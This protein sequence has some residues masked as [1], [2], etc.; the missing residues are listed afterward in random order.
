MTAT[1]SALIMGASSGIGAATARALSAAGHAV[2]LMARRADQLEALAQE[3][4]GTW[5]AVDATDAK[6]VVAA[7]DDAA[8]SGPP[9]RIAVYAAGVLDVAAVDGHP[10]ES[11]RRTIDVNL[12]G[13]FYF[14]RA[15]VPHLDAGDGSS[16]SRP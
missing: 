7:V 3:T 16:S 15:I 10:L 1:S 2:H 6:A 4:S 5:S 14:A 12:N 13:A 11:W 8:N 9:I